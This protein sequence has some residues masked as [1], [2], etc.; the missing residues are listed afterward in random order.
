MSKPDETY[1]SVHFNKK[2]EVVQVDGPSGPVAGEPMEDSP[3]N[4]INR[5]DSVLVGHKPGHSPCCVIINNIRYCW[6]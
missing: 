2:G 1:F 3:A 4:G 5:I 6:C